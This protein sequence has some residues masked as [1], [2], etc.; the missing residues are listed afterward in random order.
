MFLKKTL[1]YDQMRFKSLIQGWLTIRKTTNVIYHI[2]K[3]KKK[4]HIVNSTDV[5]KSYDKI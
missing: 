2:N 4:K 5:E 1:Q 3:L